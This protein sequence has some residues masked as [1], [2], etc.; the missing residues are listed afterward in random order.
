MDE[1]TKPDLRI[2]YLEHRSMRADAARLT[3]LAVLAEREC[4]GV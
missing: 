3:E 1:P 4:P 2:G